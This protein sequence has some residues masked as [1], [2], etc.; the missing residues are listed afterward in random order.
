MLARPAAYRVQILCIRI[1]RDARGR[2]YFRHYGYRLRSSKYFY[3]A[4]TVK[5]P[6][7]ALALARPGA[8]GRTADAPTLTN[9]AFAGQTRARVRYHWFPVFA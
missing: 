2:A 4:S 1:W 6:T 9:S 3:P 7:A 5:L 8:P